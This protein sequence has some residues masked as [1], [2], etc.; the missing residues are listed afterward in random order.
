MRW[1]SIKRK[2]VRRAAV[3]FLAV[4]VLYVSSYYVLSRRGLSVSARYDLVGFVYCD[5][6]IDSEPWFEPQ[7]VRLEVALGYF[8]LPANFV[9]CVLLGGPPWARVFTPM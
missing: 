1:I 8:Y 6:F 2:A 9:D 7:K 5:Y 4:L 3:A